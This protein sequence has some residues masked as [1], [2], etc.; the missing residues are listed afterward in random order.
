MESLTLTSNG[1]EPS[2]KNEVAWRERVAGMANDDLAAVLT[3]DAGQYHRDVVALAR[4]ELQDRGFVLREEGDGSS[5]SPDRAVLWPESAAIK[6]GINLK[7]TGVGGWLLIFILGQLILRP[8]K[9][10]DIEVAQR[11]ALIQEL[12]KYPLTALL[13]KVDILL[14]VGLMAFG[15]VVALALLWKRNPLPVKLAKIYLALNP[16]AQVLMAALCSFS[17]FTAISKDRLAQA[18]MT[19]AAV[20]AIWSLIWILYFSRSKRVK[21]MYL[22]AGQS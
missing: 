11:Y 13:F 3:A 8:L 12:E 16:L 2:L 7:S 20:P 4:L 21:A 9:V 6:L 17:D 14:S 15:V 5:T 10:L 18:F 19:Q 22:D 1:K